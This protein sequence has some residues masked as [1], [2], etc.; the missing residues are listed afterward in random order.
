VIFEALEMTY[1]KPVSLKCLFGRHRPM[2]T[3]ILSRDGGFTALCDDCGAPIERVDG[4][5]W[6]QSQPL[7][8]KRDQAA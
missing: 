5:R 6:T 1:L 2:L 8:S 3:S 4:G 7:I